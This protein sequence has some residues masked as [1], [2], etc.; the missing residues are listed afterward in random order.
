MRPIYLQLM[1][2]HPPSLHTQ[3][4]GRRLFESQLVWIPLKHPEWTSSSFQL[5]FS[6]DHLRY[7]KR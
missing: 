2:P 1:S 4:K 7:V 5:E 3:S 6:A